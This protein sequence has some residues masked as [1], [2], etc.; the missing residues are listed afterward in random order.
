MKI[1]SKTKTS[2][3]G[4]SRYTYDLHGSCTMYE[5]NG[6]KTTTE[7]EYNDAG[8]I[9]RVCE[10]KGSNRTIKTFRDNKETESISIDNNGNIIFIRVTFYHDD[11]T[12]VTREDNFLTGEWR[13][14]HFDKYG[15]VSTHEGS[16]DQLPDK[17]TLKVLR[18]KIFNGEATYNGPDE[19][20]R[21]LIKY[22]LTTWKKTK[23]EEWI[24]RYTP[25]G[26]I[27]CQEQVK[28]SYFHHE[29]QYEY[30]NGHLVCQKSVC[31][32][33]DPVNETHYEYNEAGQL[34]HE[35]TS[36]I[37]KTY[38][39]DLYGNLITVLLDNTVICRYEYEYYGESDTSLYAY[40]KLQHKHHRKNAFA[41]MYSFILGERIM[42]TDPAAA[43]NIRYW[44][45]AFKYIIS[46]QHEHCLDSIQ[47]NA[48]IKF[49]N[50]I[51]LSA[52]DLQ[53]FL[54][55]ML[56]EY[57]SNDQPLYELTSKVFE[58]GA[59]SISREKMPDNWYRYFI[60]KRR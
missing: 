47:Q 38:E 32:D 54:Q 48:V 34:I 58:P 31:P 3:K 60:I 55:Y 52:A 51:T 7:Y 12:K 39:Y 1:K 30:E 16:K 35:R 59:Y 2:A 53:N 42:E 22:G 44:R 15:L 24:Y 49:L 20:Y 21:V 11:E 18:T 41:T 50:R 37:C 25:E 56:V 33:S 14:S 28:P 45:S 23:D 9:V 17:S 6:F 4:T 26:N 29:I 10:T 5:I 40:C 57:T 43:K 13:V 36:C 27:L 8:E 19:S 46:H